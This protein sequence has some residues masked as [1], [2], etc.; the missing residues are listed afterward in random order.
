[1]EAHIHGFDIT[2]D[3]CVVGESSSGGVFLLYGRLGLGITHY[4][5]GLAEWH[6][7]LGCDK[8]CS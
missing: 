8:E 3:G 2:G 4:N 7:L 6:H 1:M 5:E